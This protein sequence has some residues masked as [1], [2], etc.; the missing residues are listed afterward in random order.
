MGCGNAFGGTNEEDD[1]GAAGNPDAPQ[2]VIDIVHYF[3]LVNVPVT[4]AI[5]KAYFMD[6][7]KMTKAQLEKHDADNGT[8]LGELFK[9]N[10]PALKTFGLTTVYNDI[11]SYDL[12]A[13][14]C[15]LC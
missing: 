3:Q 14:C 15:S 11:D 4:K 2:P 10:F 7:C 5:W 6:W 9:K 12:Y 8:K 13:F 1:G